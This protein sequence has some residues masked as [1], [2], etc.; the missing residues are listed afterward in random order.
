MDNAIDNIFEPPSN[1]VVDE[2]RQ[3]SSSSSTSSSSSLSIHYGSST[4][5]ER[6]NIYSIEINDDDDDADEGF[7]SLLGVD[8]NDDDDTADEDNFA[9][10]GN[11]DTPPNIDNNNLDCTNEADFRLLCKV[12]CM[13]ELRTSFQP[14]GHMMACESC[15]VKLFVCGI[16]REPIKQRSRVIIS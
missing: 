12:C 15:A 2:G 4:D 8:N 7:V 16:C 13:S 9:T 5:D 14:C 11:I 10:S 3:L 6:N 1:V